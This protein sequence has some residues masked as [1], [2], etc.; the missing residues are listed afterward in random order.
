MHTSLST[1]VALLAIT[2][3]LLGVL[4]VAQLGT[5]S[6]DRLLRDAF[7]RRAEHHLQQ[8][9]EQL[10][11]GLE[12]MRHDVRSLSEMRLVRALLDGTLAG[13]ERVR[14]RADVAAWV[15]SLIHDGS[16][17]ARISLV[18]AADQG[19]EV[20]R[21]DRG[22]SGAAV[23]VDDA[24]LRRLSDSSFLAQTLALPR[25]RLYV[26][27]ARLSRENGQIVA[28]HV[29]V[30]RIA[31]P[32]WSATATVSGLVIVD[33]DFSLL[34]RTL[35]QH[36]ENEFLFL[37][38]AA[39]DYL[40]HPDR[41]R[42]FRFESGEG[43]GLLRDYPEVDFAA[44]TS[45]GMVDLPER[46][47]G[48]A[49][50]RIPFDPWDQGRYFVLGTVRS[51]HAV[52]VQS[53]EYWREILILALL[54]VL[55]LGVI[56]AVV[57]RRMT[58][59]VRELTRV[60]ERIAAGEERV[61]LPAAHDADEVAA[62]SRAFR[63]M[64]ERLRHT[65]D[66]LRRIGA[67]QERQIAER[68]ADLA[69]ARDQAMAASQA[70]SGFLAT[71][72][73]EIRTPMNVVLGMLEMMRDSRLASQT[74]EQVDLAYGAGKALLALVNN[75]L[76]FSRIEADQLVLDQVDFDLRQL[77]DEVAMTL[78][79]L[80]H[81]KEVELSAFFPS[82]P[83]TAVRGDPTRLRQIFTNLL[84]NAIKFTPEGGLVELH[85]GPVAQPDDRVEF[86]FEVRDTGIGISPEDRKRI[87]HRFTRLD[88]DR[89]RHHE[90]TGLGLAI[91]R[92]LVGLMD[93]EIDVDANPFANSG[94]VFHFS[95]RLHRQAAPVQAGPDET[96]KGM[97]I[98]A[99]AS[100]QLQRTLL[101][102][103]LLP[104]G[105]HLD[106]VAEAQTAPEVLY[107]AERD[108]RGYGL[109]IFNQKPGQQNGR[110]FRKL[111][112][113]GR[114]LRFILL[115]D[116]M[117][118]GWDQAAEMPGTAICLKKPISA[119][120]L[121]AAIGWLRKTGENDAGQAEP[122]PPGEWP[123][124]RLSTP[125]LLVDDQMANLVVAKGLLSGLGCD[126]AAMDTA[127]NGAEALAMV[128]TR[129]YGLIF[130]DCQMP[131]M[132]GHAAT[133][134]IRDLERELGRPPTPVIAFT[135]DITP[136]SRR[137]VAESGMDHFLA[138]PVAKRDLAAVLSRFV[139]AQAV[140]SP[141]APEAGG[142]HEPASPPPLDMDAL[143][144]SLASIGLP[145]EDFQEV[146]TMLSQQFMELVRTMERELE[147]Q[148]SQSAR[149]TA[150]VLKG[151]MANTIFPQIQRATR[152][153]YEAV[154]DREWDGA[155]VALQ[156]VRERFS[157]IQA[158]LLIYLKQAA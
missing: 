14:V 41:Q 118:Q 9:A 44:A 111:V 132:D 86:L 124:S 84:G 7:V 120:R 12:A 36:P 116:L 50:T 131:V 122:M 16:I 22:A 144:E 101:E 113:V 147:R 105:A 106:H 129:A 139:P 70:K 58:R 142:G 152:A 1:K 52:D 15:A 96:L 55:G 121:N 45:G 49:F 143:L 28:P 92:H 69:E 137:L 154:R 21:V 141:S 126:V 78:A 19:R 54:V 134:A 136:Q 40:H 155:M 145:E 32:V 25:G 37:G 62:L 109:V 47:M 85:G 67:D 13:S 66:E 76:D 72:S 5:L 43:G 75:A 77:V 29:P 17:H 140:P 127:L 79:S 89:A 148:D 98:L 34:A 110:T 57:V 108:G 104:R 35:E 60:A 24:Q 88:S 158:A 74:R 123:A 8:Q 146:A 87:F 4:M 18:S 90:G 157:P 20:V 102:N 63:A 117:D 71:M 38:N 65:H 2:F 115:T 6:V 64:L 73:H 48:L 151:S 100:D 82:G 93:G 10:Q 114:P 125:I 112:H 128:K 31:M 156:D 99:V 150:H 149:A 23:T 59:P 135:A 33:A 94:S 27:D 68:T 30:I 130:M 61:E 83:T 46:R 39:G 133:R 81:A 119:E 95:I 3:T 53:R 153:L 11:A 103:I 97:R 80:A 91:C 56:V 42:R 138:K 26:S 51:Y 107:R